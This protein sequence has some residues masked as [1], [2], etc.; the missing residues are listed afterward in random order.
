[1]LNW[2]HMIIKQILK[3]EH[4]LL[5]IVSGRRMTS[6]MIT[7]Q[8]RRDNTENKSRYSTRT[9]V[10]HFQ[11]QPPKP[12][13]LRTQTYS[14]VFVENKVCE[15]KPGK[16]FCDVMTFV[17]LWPIRFHDRMKLEC[18]LQRI[19]RAV[20][21]GLLE[22]SCDWLK[23]PTSQI[24]FPGF[25]SQTIFSA[26]TTLSG[27]KPLG[28]AL[29]VF[30]SLVLHFHSIAQSANT[31]WFY[32]LGC[33]HIHFDSQIRSLIPLNCHTKELEEWLFEGCSKAH[34]S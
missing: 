3:R 15:T 10:S 5:R 4:K 27:Y 8:V 30:N 19:P 23:N 6:W 26:E 1:M 22:L 16:E 17:S 13:S 12:L 9:G 2:E 34:S 29:F 32:F 20:V 21:L 28:H 24:S 31:F 14:L 33:Y 25:G 18:S 7:Y 11:I